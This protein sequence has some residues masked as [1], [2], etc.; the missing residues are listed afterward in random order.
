VTGRVKLLIRSGGKSVSPEEVE[1]VIRE[2][3][4]VV[5]VAVFGLADPEWG[6]IVAA[7]VVEEPGRPVSHADIS[8]HCASFLSSHKRP[9][10][11]RTLPALPRSHYGKIQLTK[12]RQMFEGDSNNL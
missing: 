1:R 7:A 5:D 11:I 3:P 6:E 10:R 9:R 8:A 12:L 4:G 2:I